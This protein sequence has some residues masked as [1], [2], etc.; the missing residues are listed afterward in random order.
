MVVIDRQKLTYALVGMLGISLVIALAIA[1]SAVNSKA[2]DNEQQTA[3]GFSF[4]DPAISNMDMDHYMRTK[5]KYTASYKPLKE[6]IQQILSQ[7]EGKFG[8][9]F[10]DL[11]FHSWFGI[12]EREQFLPASML[13]TTTVAAILMQVQEG[14]L[15]LD[16][17][18]TINKDDLNYR[19]GDLYEKEG[20][21]FTIK[22]LIEIAM[23]D[24][25]NTAIKALHKYMLGERWL[26]ARL[27]MGLPIASVKQSEN[28]TALT[29]KEF[30]SVFRSLYYSGYL[31]RPFSN[32]ILMLLS[33]TDFNNGIPAGVPR[34]VAVSH[35]IGEWASDGSVHDCG[36]VYAKKP[37]ILC[38]MSRDTTLEEG[39]R[40]ITEI[41]KK[42]YDFVSNN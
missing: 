3:A 4:L 29:P 12:N 24:S 42:V 19:F 40:V 35:K 6:E 20:N 32:W 2:N 16:Q 30:S 11:T 34:D 18:V 26:E 27:V 5:E 17:E 36:I 8:V 39:N 31:N 14:E 15:S 1:Y 10:E 22:E 28:G 41:S 23:I 38:I 25:D 33:E 7:S 9:Y 21:T 13:K 37:Y